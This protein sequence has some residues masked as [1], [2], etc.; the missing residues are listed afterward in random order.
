MAKPVQ[1][2]VQDGNLGLQPGSNQNVVLLMGC[3]LGNNAGGGVWSTPTLYNYGDPVTAQNSL[4]GGEL[5]EVVGYVL[6]SAPGSLV[7]AVPLPPTTRGG[8]GSVTHTG[9]GALVITPSIGPQGAITVSCTTGGTLGTAAFTFAV[10]DPIT[11][12]TVTSAPVTSA[13]DGVK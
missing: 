7:Q 13:S 11:G 10:T 5:L 9:P 8:V 2:N 1:V 12:V 3:C 4:K 6:K